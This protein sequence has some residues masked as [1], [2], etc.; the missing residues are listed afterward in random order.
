MNSIAL[1]VGTLALAS[2]AAAQTPSKARVDAIWSAAMDRIVTQNDA[3]FED[4]EF[5]KCIQSLRIQYELN[6]ADYEI[7]TNL[8]WML[9]NI[10][11]T[12]EEV[13]VY[14]RYKRENPSDPDAV[15]PLAQFYGMKRQFPQVITLL[16][17]WD[18]TKSHPNAW[19]LLANAY[20]RQGMLKDSQRVYQAF[21][22]LHPNDESAKA[23]LR[24]VEADLAKGSR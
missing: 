9:G 15:L 4:G 18:K 16:E 14:T 1:V 17:P 2:P 3:W 5:P 24:R 19:R 10:E 20:R 8:G 6:P 13:A 7:A 21:I 23:N 22:K 12:A 11:E